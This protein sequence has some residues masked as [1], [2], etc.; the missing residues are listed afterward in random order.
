MTTAIP[1]PHVISEDD[2]QAIIDSYGDNPQHVGTDDDQDPFGDLV[3]EFSDA[4]GLGDDATDE[5]YQTLD[6][7]MVESDAT[8]M[9]ALA[10]EVEAAFGL[11]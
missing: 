3:I 4:L 9:R 6:Q 10:R 8:T 2:L 5:Q 11:R 7:A 1:T